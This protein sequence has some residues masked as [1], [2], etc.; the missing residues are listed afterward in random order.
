MT[1]LGALLE[2]GFEVL[3]VDHELDWDRQPDR[4]PLFAAL[5][6]VRI[7]LFWMAELDP[8]TQF[9]ASLALA[10]EF[11]RSIPQLEVWLGGEFIAILPED[12]LHPRPPIH[13]FVRDYGEEV[14]ADLVAARLDGRSPAAIPGLVYVEDGRRRT[15][16][17]RS[18][19]PFRSSWLD[20]YRQLDLSGHIQ[21]GGGIFGNRQ[22]TLIL[23]TARGCPK[24]CDFCY[25]SSHRY[26][27]ADPIAIVD[28]A[29][30]LRQ[31]YGVRQFHIAELDF[32]PSKKR[33]DTFCK[34]FSARLPDSTWFA[35]M[36]PIDAEK[37]SLEDWRML[38]R[39]GCRKIEFGI[40]TASPA[41][42]AKIGKHHGP[43]TALEVVRLC[44][45]HGIEPMLNFV[46]GL[47]G[48][49]D[50]DRQA[51]IRFVLAVLALPGGSTA[52]FTF[53]SYQPSYDTALGAP[54]IA[55]SPG[56]PR[57]LEGLLESR[58]AFE[59]IDSRTFEWISA[60][61]ERLVKHLLAYHLPLAT[62]QLEP[63]GRVDQWI[64]RTLRQL[65]RWRLS[66]GYFGGPDESRIYRWRAQRHFSDRRSQLNQTFRP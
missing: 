66:N 2:A 3:W 23:G 25:W 46:F 48:E 7:G 65:S 34:E 15:T 5:A 16:P 55:A 43:A 18:R 61:E 24:H 6:E 27:M 39:S 21:R 9:L 41:I 29:E 59:S 63:P 13:G 45:E 50:Q 26:S 8:R 38:F 33:L 53:R 49:T 42:L 64:Y 20:A 60:Q 57:T 1:V 32:A 28:I 4:S 47:P 54:T 14:V 52:K 31:R 19:G 51:S 30:H 56:F 12:M 40:E 62:S 37:F 17:R 36:S 35:L 44:I 11:R 10:E 22:P 58:P